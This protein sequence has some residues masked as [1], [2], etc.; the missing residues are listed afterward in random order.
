MPVTSCQA[1]CWVEPPQ[2]ISIE[3]GFRF[4]K[5]AAA[6][7]GLP[8]GAR[9]LLATEMDARLTARSARGVLAWASG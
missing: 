9:R 5:E 4:Y 6:F 3:A 2:N 1:F 7:L 8:R